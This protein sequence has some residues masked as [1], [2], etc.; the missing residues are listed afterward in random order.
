MGQKPFT[1]N[2]KAKKYNNLIIK[3][4]KYSTTGKYI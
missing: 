1:S 2:E 4:I 3:K